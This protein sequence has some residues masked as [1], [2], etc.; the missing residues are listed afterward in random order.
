M[1]QQEGAMRIISIIGDPSVI[2]AIFKSGHLAGPIQSTP[3]IHDPPVYMYN[4]GRPT[5]PY[6]M[7]EVSQLPINEDHLHR[8]PQ[9]SWEDCPQA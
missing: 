2:R 6:I 3:K 1:R 7:D 4:K 5:A 9:Y 8:D